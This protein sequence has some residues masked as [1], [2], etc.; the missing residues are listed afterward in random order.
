MFTY[1]NFH[2]GLKKETKLKEAKLRQRYR[3][4]I[5]Y[6]LRTII[7]VNRHQHVHYK[8]SKNVRQGLTL[9][10]NKYLA[11]QLHDAR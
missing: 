5:F 11:A 4:M 1:R 8:P 9:V 10:Q 6:F 7:F 2:C 3:P